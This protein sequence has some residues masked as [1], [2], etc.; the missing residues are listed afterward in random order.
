LNWDWKLN[1]KAYGGLKYCSSTTYIPRA[2]SVRRKY[3][4]A[5]SKADSLLSS[6]RS[7]F[8]NR[9]PAGGGPE[10]V[11]YRRLLVENAATEEVVGVKGR[12]ELESLTAGRLRT[13][14]IVKGFADAMLLLLVAGLL[15]RGVFEDSVPEC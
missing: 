15:K 7:G 6:H 13:T 2:I 3:L 14:S 11:A 1:G 10:G 9:K 5:L 12:T 8:G 4:P